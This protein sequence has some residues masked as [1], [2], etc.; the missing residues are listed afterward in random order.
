MPM[1]QVPS[2]RS[3]FLWTLALWLITHPCLALD[4][5]RHAPLY[6]LDVA[7]FNPIGLGTLL[8]W[9]E[10]GQAT[11][12]LSGSPGSDG[13]WWDGQTESKLETG[14]RT[15]AVGHSINDAGRIAG[16]VGTRSDRRAAIWDSGEL[17]VLSEFA[18]LESQG[19]AVNENGTVAGWFDT[20]D[21]D[22][23]LFTWDGVVHEYGVLPSRSPRIRDVNN[24]LQIIGHRGTTVRGGWLWENNTFHAL[25][26]LVGG[27]DSS[28]R[29]INEGG[30]VVGN[31][32]VG[33]NLRAVKWVDKQ[34]VSLPFP[35]NA[36]RTQAFAINDD[37][38][39]VGEAFFPETANEIAAMLWIGDD[40]YVLDDL[41]VNPG[42]FKLLNALEISESG[43]ILAWAGTE[44]R[45][46]RIVVLTPI[47]EPATMLIVLFGLL[48][49]SSPARAWG[50]Q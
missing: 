2:D 50:F 18:G 28:P 20:E 35:V 22:S 43:R 8:G 17:M 30:V 34:V 46:T 36:I 14:T 23:R 25:P 13:Y 6:R 4:T 15:D 39:I 7:P 26:D 40:F 16:W 12:I 24:N 38:A 33:P 27:D 41:V 1:L 37:G 9:N 45:G 19:Y 47:P 48:V 49:L 10:S 3:I 11:Y 31:S 42:D 29:D 44:S 32:W 21:L 5:I